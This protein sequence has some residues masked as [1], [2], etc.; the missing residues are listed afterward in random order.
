M[1]V[2]RE[3]GV[4]LRVELF[5]EEAAMFV[6]LLLELRNY[7]R[8]E[9]TASPLHMG[10]VLLQRLQRDGEISVDELASSTK[11]TLIYGYEGAY[12]DIRAW[13]AG[14]LASDFDDSWN[15]WQIYKAEKGIREAGEES[16]GATSSGGYF[17]VLEPGHEGA[18]RWG[19]SR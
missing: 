8:D 13:L 9:R 3:P 19:R 18:H 7:E 14:H 6:Q 16:C 5:G 1:R 15:L 2:E 12:K 4:P 10:L 11:R 17:C